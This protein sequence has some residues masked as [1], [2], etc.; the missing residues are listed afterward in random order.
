MRVWGSS[1]CRP[2]GTDCGPPLLVRAA[3][4]PPNPGHSQSHRG[5]C[6]LSVGRQT[7]TAPWPGRSLEGLR[8]LR[9]EPHFG[10]GAWGTPQHMIGTRAYPR[11]L[12]HNSQPSVWDQPGCLSLNDEWIKK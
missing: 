9:A 4:G 12:R 3:L 11:P 10:V 8:G 6:A 7:S 1:V 5:P 2:E